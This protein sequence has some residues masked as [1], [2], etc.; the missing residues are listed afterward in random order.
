MRPAECDGWGGKLSGTLPRHDLPQEVEQPGEALAGDV[1]A[2]PELAVGGGAA[3]LPVLPSVLPPE[4]VPERPQLAT[5]ARIRLQ[6]LDGGRDAACHLLEAL[7][8]EAVA[9]LLLGEERRPA[10]P[11]VPL[12]GVQEVFETEGLDAQPGQLQEELP[13]PPD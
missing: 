13:Q 8:G 11:R 6:A 2:L 10:P 9:A 7:P 1:Q 3:G 5:G 4:V 12:Q